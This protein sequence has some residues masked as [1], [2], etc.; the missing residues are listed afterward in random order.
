M[1]GSNWTNDQLKAYEQ[2]RGHQR[3]VVGSVAFEPA[4]KMQILHDGE[5]K[6]VV[7]RPTHGDGADVFPPPP[8]A[9]EIVDWRNGMDRMNKTER[10]YSEYL[11]ALGVLWQF[12]EIK[13]R[14]AD[15]TLYTPD[16]YLPSLAEFREIKGYWEDDARVK[17]KIVARLFPQWK[18]TAV[19]K[20]K[21]GWEDC[22]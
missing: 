13:L 17:F 15:R 11:T 16:F 22:T 19:R 8:T 2:K 21:H 14:L 20:G 5:S 9:Q 6:A 10:A 1:T 7:F 18:F 12:E 3:P 4:R